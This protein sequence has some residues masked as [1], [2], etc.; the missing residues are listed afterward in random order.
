MPKRKTLAVLVLSIVLSGVTWVYARQ[1]RT[2]GSLTTQDYI[3][4]QQLYARYNNAIDGGD[5]EGYAAT[6]VADGVFNTFTGHDALV[7]FINEW[8]DKRNGTSRR[9]WNTNLT[10]SG[11]PEGASGSVYLMLLD[12]SVRPPVIASTA[13]YED[14]LVKTPQGWRFKKRATRADAAAPRPAQ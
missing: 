6:F 7:G 8:R 3:D 1:S 5:A 9:H 4:I 2:A 10:I 12:V 14:A 11:T 13:K